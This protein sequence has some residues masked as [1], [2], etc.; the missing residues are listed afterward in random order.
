L[1][2]K[3]AGTWKEVEAEKVEEKNRKREREDGWEHVEDRE[4]G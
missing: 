2:K 3:G 1:R 4:R